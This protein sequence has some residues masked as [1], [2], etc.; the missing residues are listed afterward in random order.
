MR[1]V[2]ASN[3]SIKNPFII[4]GMIIGALG[5]I[6]PIVVVVY[7]YLGLYNHFEGKLFSPLIKLIAPTPFI[8]KISFVVIILGIFVGMLGSARAVRKYLKV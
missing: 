4:E 1:L 8:Y 5:S 2:G 6:I 7:G 3:F